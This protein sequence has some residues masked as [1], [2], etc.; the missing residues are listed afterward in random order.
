MTWAVGSVRPVSD[1]EH[2]SRTSLPPPSFHTQHS[3]SGMT[4]N[5][6][7]PQR[8]TVDHHLTHHSQLHQTHHQ[9]RRRYHHKYHHVG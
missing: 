9:Q 4:K 5:E 7:L 1:V 2:N 6:P 3:G 8:V